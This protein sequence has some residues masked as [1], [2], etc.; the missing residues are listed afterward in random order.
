MLSIIVSPLWADQTQ[1]TLLI[2]LSARKEFFQGY[3]YSPGKEFFQRILFSVALV[4]FMRPKRICRKHIVF[5]CVC[6][7]VSLTYFF[8]FFGCGHD[9][10]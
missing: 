5:S 2:F 1:E 4:V 7:F 8:F 6:D 10:S 3:C 9:N